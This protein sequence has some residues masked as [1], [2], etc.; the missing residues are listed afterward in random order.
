[1]KRIAGEDDDA[2]DTFD[3]TKYLVEEFV[4]S[5]PSHSRGGLQGGVYEWQG[6]IADNLASEK[7]NV[8]LLRWVYYGRDLRLM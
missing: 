3:A 2:G 7:S 5:S 1:M 4:A 6:G 8:A